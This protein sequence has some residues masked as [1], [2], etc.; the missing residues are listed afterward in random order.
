MINIQ[1]ES[2]FLCTIAKLVMKRILKRLSPQ[3][4]E[5]EQRMHVGIYWHCVFNTVTKWKS[6]VA[7]RA[8][9]PVA[10]E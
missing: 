4:A 3:H 2:G 7:S 6:S 8:E 10:D 9:Q 5:T 1:R